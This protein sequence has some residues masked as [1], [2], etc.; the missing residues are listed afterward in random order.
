M[1]YVYLI[2][3]DVEL[4]RR[5]VGISTDLKR[6]LEAHNS[7]QSLHTVKY[8]PWH[9]VTYLAF[10]NQKKAEEFERYLKSGLGHAFA[11]KRLW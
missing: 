5:Y 10:S 9:L 7:G 11:R 6:R 8:R 3:S 1:H 4:G 2:E